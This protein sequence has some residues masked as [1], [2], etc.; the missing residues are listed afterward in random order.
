[1]L[2]F[3]RYLLKRFFRTLLVCFTSAAGL[4]VVI[5]VF[6]NLEE[7]I[8]LG[9]RHGGMARVVVEYYGPRVALVFDRI[10]AFLI[11]LAAM[12]TITWLHRSNELTALFAAGVSP[13]RIAR[14]LIGAAVLVVAISAVN[15][16]LLIP[17]HRDQ[18][19]RNA[20][21]W[22]GSRARAIYPRRDHRTDI[23]LNGEASFP[24]ERRIS[25]PHFSFD[26]PLANFG[27][28]VAA[29]N[30]FYQAATAERAAGYLLD[31]VTTPESI[32]DLPSLVIAGAPTLLTPRDCAWLERDQCFLVS[33]V[34]FEQVAGGAG[35]R[36]FSSTSQL[37][38]GLRNSSL[39][40]GADVRVEIHS[41]MVRP[42]LELSLLFLGLPLAFL[43]DHRNVFLAAGKGVLLALAFIV[44]VL[45][46]QGM[47]AAY[48]VRPALAAW[49]PLLLFIPLAVYLNEPLSRAP[50]VKRREA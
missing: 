5:D 47:G 41:R 48:W 11:L 32:A 45:A 38:S 28:Y 18:L 19:T 24:G 40:F 29:E 21:D 22:L 17:A 37:L 7:F 49:A 42:L 33:D 39:D 43:A 4:F 35:W 2:L 27:R 15:R 26:E 46:C 3:D 34:D 8:T 20:Q 31:N 23:L 30:A 9:E 50:P 1:M 16:E 12:F 6:T 10:G 14:P 36:Q 44:V 25:R 13:R